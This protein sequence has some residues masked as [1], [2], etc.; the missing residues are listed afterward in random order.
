MFLAMGLNST[1]HTYCLQ[2]RSAELLLVM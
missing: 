1:E 2:Q